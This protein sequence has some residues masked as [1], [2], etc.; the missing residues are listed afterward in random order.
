MV[1]PDEYIDQPLFANTDMAKNWHKLGFIVERPSSGPLPIFVEVQRSPI[2][3]P[4]KVVDLPLGAI[5]RS[6]KQKH[7]PLVLP[8]PDDDECP[9]NNIGS[10]RE[11]L[12]TAMAIEL[13]TIPLYLFAMYSIK[14]PAQYA[15]DP[16]YYDPIIAAI[17]GKHLFCR[18][19]YF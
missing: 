9:I 5:P 13:A 11:H 15:R 14:T 10:L 4:K 2:H 19:E 3:R 17:R 1:Y 12:Q 7:G 8:T 6:D 18:E 16:R